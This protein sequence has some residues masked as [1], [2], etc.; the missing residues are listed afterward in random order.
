VTEAYVRPTSYDV[1]VFPDEMASRPDACM[2]ADTWKITVEARGLGTWGICFMGRCLGISGE[3]DREPI[4]SSRDDDWLEDH[5]FPLAA[6]LD[7]AREYAP[8][9]KINGMTALEILERHRA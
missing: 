4:P 5:R 7:L 2:D 3:W 9:V 1:S 8:K 6:A